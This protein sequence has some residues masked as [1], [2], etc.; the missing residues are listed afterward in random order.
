MAD[1]RDTND[2]KVAR[3]EQ[4]K[5]MISEEVGKAIEISIPRL[6]QEVESHV[7]ELVETMMSSKMDELKGMIGEIQGTKGTRR[8]TYKEFMA[9]NPLPY[10]E[11]IDPIACQRWIAS[12]EAVFVRS[13]CEKEYQVMFATGLF[14]LQDKDWWDAY[15]KEIGEDRVQAL[16]WQEFK[17]PFLKYHCLQS[18]I[19]RIQ[20]DFLR[21][22][23]KDESIDEITNIFLD[24]LKFC[25]EIV[26]TERMKI[27]RYHDMLKVKYR[28][29]ITPSKCETL[30]ELIN[31]T[32]DREIKLKRQVERGEKRTSENVP[33]S[34]PSKKQ[35]F[36]DPDK[37]D[38][39]KGNFPKCKTCGKL[40]T[41]ECLKGKKGCY[42]FGQEG[43]PYCKCPIPPE[44]VI[45]VFNRVMLRLNALSSNRRRVRKEEKRKPQRLRV[46]CSRYPLKK[47]RLFRMSFQVYF[48]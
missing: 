20:E 42:N 19:D 6:T 27:I 46:E 43:H 13:H 15:C 39:T 47:P 2:D 1:N 41:E 25:R 4:V 31:W 22:R 14:Q 11:E 37:K 30:N 26:G 38:K 48:N 17:E 33:N 40:Q 23:Q 16:T 44:L 29:F 5:V 35:K 32:W 34:G 21:L 8:C 9:C 3:Q 10:K 45:T 28:E 36:Q 18:A 24:K 12:T 7:L